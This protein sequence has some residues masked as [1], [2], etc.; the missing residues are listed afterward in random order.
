MQIFQKD[1]FHEPQ[2]LCNILG[3]KR[4]RII[5]Y[6]PI[7]LFIYLNVNLIIGWIF[8]GHLNLTTQL[9]CEICTGPGRGSSA[10]VCPDMKIMGFNY[11]IIFV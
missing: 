5:V 8:L 3:L 10:S 4:Q 2:N 9:H 7:C 6:L 11:D 1:I